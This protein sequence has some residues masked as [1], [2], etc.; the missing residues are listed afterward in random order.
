MGLFDFGK[1]KK[2]KRPQKV[3]AKVE[4]HTDK[5]YRMY[6]YDGKPLK[7]MRKNTFFE[8][9]YVARKTKLRS[10]YT[11]NTDEFPGAFFVGK[12]AIGG[13]FSDWMNDQLAKRGK[14]VT[15]KCKYEGMAS[16]GWPEV[17]FYLPE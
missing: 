10:A 8:A 17:R 5:S 13:T 12:V 16:G 2:P 3:A 15:V 6:V 1:P 7:G 11:G 9:K 4:V 14:S